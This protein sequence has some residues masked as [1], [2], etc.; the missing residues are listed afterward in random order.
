MTSPRV[1]HLVY[2]LIRG[3]TEGQCA[4]VAVG[5][6]KQGLPH[7]VAV[8]HRRGFYLDRVEAACGPV[9]ELTIRHLLRWSTVN[10]VRAFAQ[11]LCREKVDILHAWDA[12]AAIFG[13]LA[14][15]WN[16]V[17]LIT[18]RRDQAVVMMSLEDYEALEET[19]YLL[20][21]PRNATRLR[22]AIDQLRRGQGKERPLP[23]LE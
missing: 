22:E 6:A 23:N 1:V 3:G 12:D 11:W 13:Q 15:K 17:K 4:Q 19:A 2:D 7:R 9:Y 16:G 21:S 10:E 8:F 14:A 5:L 18:R 20:R